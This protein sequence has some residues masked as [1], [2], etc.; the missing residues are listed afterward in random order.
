MLAALQRW[1]SEK[2]RTIALETAEGRLSYAVLWRA[3]DEAAARLRAHAVRTAALDLPNGCGWVIAHLACLHAG[4]AQV[5]LPPF[6]TAAQRTHALCDAGADA[7][8]TPAEPADAINGLP[9]SIAAC[10]HAPVPL[11]TGTALVTYTSGS[12]GAPRGVCLG[13]QGM[14]RVAQSLLHVLG[15]AMAQRHLS[16]LPLAVL[17]EQVGGLYPVLLAGGTYVMRPDPLS[18]ALRLSR[19]ESCILVPELLK[20]LLHLPGDYPHLRFVAVGGARVDPALLAQAAARGLPAYEGYGL[21]EAAS[22]VAVNTPRHHKPGTVGK[23]LPH[24][25]YHQSADGEIILHDPAILGYAGG[26]S[27]HG[28]YATGDLGT[29]D[30][31]GFLS[32]TGRK[33]NLLITAHGRNIAP[34]WPESLLTAQPEIAQACVYGD[35]QTSLHALVVPTAD[36]AGVDAALARVNAQLPEYAHIG[37]WRCVAPFTPENGM[38]TGNGRLRRAAILSTHAKELNDGFLRPACA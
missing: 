35:G 23:I 32:I 15:D 34:E 19:A 10:S 25:R 17:L 28:D 37:Q 14:M 16:V 3:V 11:P 31:A 13:V 5:P 1:A 21:S 8:L 20:R 4:V 26:A 7:V 2:P 38:A 6:F 36:A 33:K 24:I 29:V 27:W 18:E 30:A 9:F 22:V 12:T